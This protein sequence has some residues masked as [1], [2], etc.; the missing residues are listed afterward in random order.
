MEGK[1]L[2]FRVEKEWYLHDVEKIREIIPY[3]EPNPVPGSSEENLGMLN[4]RGEVKSIFSG[5]RLLSLPPESDRSEMRI[6]LFDTSKGEFGVVVDDVTEILSIDSETIEPPAD[7]V[8]NAI[9]VG[10]V[11]YK[12]R[13]YIV[14]DFERGESIAFEN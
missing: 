4:L 9:I 1:W 3:T 11:Q 10:T 6:I 7:G 8:S 2:C 13:L 14:A 5:R 12:E